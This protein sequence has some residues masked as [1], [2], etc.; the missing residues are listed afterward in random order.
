MFQWTSVDCEE[1]EE[2]DDANADVGPILVDAVCIGFIWD[3]GALDGQDVVAEG[4][5]VSQDS[6]FPFFSQHSD[7]VGC[8]QR[9]W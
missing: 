9:F 5:G 1:E 2:E 3:V 7:E 8:G 6:T 4:V